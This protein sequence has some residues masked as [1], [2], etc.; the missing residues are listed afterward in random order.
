MLPYIKLR[1]WRKGSQWFE[2]H[3][4]LAV[5]IVADNMYYIIFRKH[6]L[7]ACYPDEHYIP[8]YLNMFHGSQNSNRTTT[9]VDWSKGGPHPATYEKANITK[10]LIQTIRNNGTL[11]RYNSEMTS[12][13]YLFARKFA[14]SEPDLNNNGIL[15][16]L[17]LQRW[18]S[19]RKNFRVSRFC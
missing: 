6:C 14:P 18:D 1:H 17:I 12:V 10:D 7:P 19:F 4:T 11:C 5:N 9:W 13:C 2:L 3:R 15:K 8:T 16:I